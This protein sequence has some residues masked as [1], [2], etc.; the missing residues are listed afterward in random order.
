[1]EHPS[2]ARLTHPGTGSQEGSL[3]LALAGGGPK[4]LSEVGR[5]EQEEDGGALAEVLATCEG[6]SASLRDLL[7]SQAR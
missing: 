5:V 1:M 6:I 4:A 3:S 2:S 7:G